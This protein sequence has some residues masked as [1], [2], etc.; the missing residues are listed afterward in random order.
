MYKFTITKSVYSM[1]YYTKNDLIF[2][3]FSLNIIKRPQSIINNPQTNVICSHTSKN[4]F[5]KK[6]QKQKK[7]NKNKTKDFFFK[8][9][10]FIQKDSNPFFSASWARLINTDFLYPPKQTFL[11]FFFSFYFY[12]FLFFLLLFSALKK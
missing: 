1:F 7:K 9:F 2:Y 8:V 12:S 4:A 6:K 11:L 3:R 10:F 5:C